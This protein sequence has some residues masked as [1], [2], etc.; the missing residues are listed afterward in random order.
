MLLDWLLLDWLIAI[1]CRWMLAPVLVVRRASIS[2]SIS[3]G[4]PRGTDSRLRYRFRAHL[5]WRGGAPCWLRWRMV[6]GGGRGRVSGGT[7][8]SRRSLPGHYPSTTT[9]HTYTRTDMAATVCPTSAHRITSLS[10]TLQDRDSRTPSAG[11]VFSRTPS[12]GSVFSRE[13]A[14]Q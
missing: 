14:Q 12:A 4:H 10:S 3:L 6:E 7:R 8:A 2:P 9:H 1:E 13:A 11:S 5:S